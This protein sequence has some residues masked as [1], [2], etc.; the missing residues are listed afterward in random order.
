LNF[1]EFKKLIAVN[2]KYVVENQRARHLHENMNESQVKN[3]RARNLHENMN[4]YQVDN[5]R[6]RNL[7]ENMNEY[8]VDNHR[9]RNLREI[10]NEYQL[11][12]HRARNLQ[13]NRN[14]RFL[15]IAQ[16]WDDEHP[17]QYC[18]SVYLKSVKKKA[19]NR[20]C[21]NGAYLMEDSA[22]PKLEMLPEALK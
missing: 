7:R 4:E 5:H 17:C 18:F 15:P 3:H 22:F 2:N 20:C 21:N 12:N 1:S 14:T 13:E 10:M 6:A 9:A 19:R 16:E 11:D 8:Q